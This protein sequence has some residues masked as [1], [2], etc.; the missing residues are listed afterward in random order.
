MEALWRT[1]R[2]KLVI[3]ALAV[4]VVVRVCVADRALGLV[5]AT[6]ERGESATRVRHR[7]RCRDHVPPLRITPPQT[8]V[9]RTVNQALEQSFEP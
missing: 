3:A 2:A 7:A 6:D 4:G 8:A 9:E 1:A 5:G